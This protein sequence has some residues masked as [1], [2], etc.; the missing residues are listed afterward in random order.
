[1]KSRKQY[2][3]CVRGAKIEENE[4]NNGKI[5]RKSNQSIKYLFSTAKC[6]PPP[7]GTMEPRKRE[8]KPPEID[9]AKSA[10]VL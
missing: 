7:L 9:L 1:M 3:R 10:I 4:R 6:T 8:R 5:E 2:E